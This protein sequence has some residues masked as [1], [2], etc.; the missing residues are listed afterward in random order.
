ML[1]SRVLNED[2]SFVLFCVLCFLCCVVSRRRYAGHVCSIAGYG[3]Q[4]CE[5]GR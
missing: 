4:R 3:E 5:S 1:N 2:A